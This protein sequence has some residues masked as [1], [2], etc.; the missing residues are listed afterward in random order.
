MIINIEQAKQFGRR[1]TKKTE[2]FNSSVFLVST[3]YS[4][5][6]GSTHS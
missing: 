4:R 2:E 5:M 1:N 6:L 3:V